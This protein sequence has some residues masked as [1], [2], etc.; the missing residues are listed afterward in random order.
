[1]VEFID[2]FR[3]FYEEHK[4]EKNNSVSSF[5][6]NLL[7]DERKI[8]DRVLVTNSSAKDTELT[9]PSHFGENHLNRRVFS[10][11]D[12][13]SVNVIHSVYMEVGNTYSVDIASDI[14]GANRAQYIS[15]PVYSGERGAIEAKHIFPRGELA[16]TT[17]TLAGNGQA[18]DA[19][20]FYK[21][22]KLGK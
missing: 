12:T 14:A 3:K 21:N 22:S 10:L 18:T 17:M 13:I 1:M 6:F 11:Q 16:R 20:A 15:D 9:K 7:E 4:Y 19:D 8:A 2:P 5:S